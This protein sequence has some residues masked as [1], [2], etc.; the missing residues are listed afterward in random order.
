MHSD[1]HVCIKW[2][3]D[4]VSAA[5]RNKLKVAASPQCLGTYGTLPNRHGIGSGSDLQTP[6]CVK[7]TVLTTR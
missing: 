3:V 7:P 5:R 4:H 2:R 6:Q 1:G